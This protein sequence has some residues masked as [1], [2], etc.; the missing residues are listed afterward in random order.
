MFGFKAKVKGVM[1]KEKF[2]RVRNEIILAGKKRDYWED[3]IAGSKN[4]E[5]EWER[6]EH[7]LIEIRHFEQ[8]ILHFE[9]DLR[10]AVG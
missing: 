5:M 6:I 1:S 10:R 7:A 8:T 3:V 9:D 4:P 2:L